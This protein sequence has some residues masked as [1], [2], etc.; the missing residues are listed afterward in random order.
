MGSFPEIIM[1]PFFGV[2]IVPFLFNLLY[3]VILVIAPTPP[4]RNSRP[5]VRRRVIAEISAVLQSI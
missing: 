4:A 2:G 1:N 5:F 3:Y